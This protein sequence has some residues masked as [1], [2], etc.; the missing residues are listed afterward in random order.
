M[1]VLDKIS[2]PTVTSEEKEFLENH[3]VLHDISWETYEQLLEIFSDRS[4]PRITFYRGSLELIRPRTEREVYS[5]H[6]GQLV[7][8]LTAAMGLEIIGFKSSTWPLREQATGKEA[9]ECFYIQNEA[10]VRNKLQIDLT[11]DPPPDLAIEVDLTHSSIDA[12]SVYGE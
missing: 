4:I 10:K 1:E 7:A 6:L 3:L 5:W 9:D 12:I 8:E 11:V 2:T